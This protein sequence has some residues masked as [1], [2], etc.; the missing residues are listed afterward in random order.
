MKPNLQRKRIE[1][2]D[3]VT[4]KVIAQYNS[5]KEGAKAVSM[6]LP[7]ISMCIAGKCKSAGTCICV[8]PFR[9]CLSSVY[10]FALVN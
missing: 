2:L 8:L 9:W 4:G 5:L 6:P 10:H 1:Q 3:L 7:C